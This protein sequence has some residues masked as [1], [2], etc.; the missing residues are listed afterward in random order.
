MDVGDL[1][2]KLLICC[3]S[4][5]FTLSGNQLEQSETIFGKNVLYCD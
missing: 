4:E 3:M 5:N 2:T 1:L